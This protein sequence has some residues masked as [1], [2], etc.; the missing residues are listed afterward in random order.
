MIRKIKKKTLF[1]VGLIGLSVIGIFQNITKTG[2]TETLTK[3]QLKNIIGMSVPSAGAETA[4]CGSSGC[5]A[6]A[7]GGDGAPSGAG[8]GSGGGGSGGPAGDG[9]GPGGDGE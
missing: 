8:G 3:E 1:F 9:D 6:G 5:D 4:G 7:G 2:G